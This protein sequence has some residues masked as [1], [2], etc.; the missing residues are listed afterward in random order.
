M[1]TVTI[2]DEVNTSC[3]AVIVIFGEINGQM[4]MRNWYN[5]ETVD[6]GHC[7]KEDPFCAKLETILGR[8]PSAARILS[9]V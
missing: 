5:L 3:L 7:C 9:N 4:V 8:L 2:S 6:S 1:K